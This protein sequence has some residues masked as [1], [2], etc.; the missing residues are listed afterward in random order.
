MKALSVFDGVTQ[1]SLFTKTGDTLFVQSSLSG[2]LGWMKN[3]RTIMRDYKRKILFFVWE[4]SVVPKRFHKA[5]KAFD[6]LWVPSMY[7][8]RIAQAFGLPVKLVPHASPAFLATQAP[9]AGPFT[10]LTVFDQ[11]S[12][13]V[14]KNPFQVVEAFKAAFG[15]SREVQLVVKST[16]LAQELKAEFAGPNVKFITEPLLAQD[17][18]QLFQKCHV[19]VSLPRSEGFGLTYLDAMAHSRPTIYSDCTAQAEFAYGTAV[20]CKE[21]EIVGDEL[22]EGVW[23]EPDFDAAVEAFRSSHKL[24]GLPGFRQA[25]TRFAMPNLILNTGAAYGSL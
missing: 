19:Y 25:L 18:Y 17:Y 22:Y 23:Y 7:C 20:P 14:R 4:S 13:V 10:F 3:G 6:E 15:Q 5:V 21:R 12:R 9:T 24:T 8:F 1:K 16:K 11:D 2:L